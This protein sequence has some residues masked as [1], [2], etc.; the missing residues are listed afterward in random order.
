MGGV[1]GELAGSMNGRESDLLESDVQPMECG[2]VSVLKQTRYVLTECILLM[3]D[4]GDF[5]NGAPSGGT[6]F[7]LSGKSSIDHDVN[8]LCH[9][10]TASEDVLSR[11]FIKRQ[12]QSGPPVP[13]SPDDE[14]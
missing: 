2:A 1:I 11:Q 6:N 4:I 8:R 5:D 7:L 3:R 13:Q 9:F 10:F 12:L 14:L